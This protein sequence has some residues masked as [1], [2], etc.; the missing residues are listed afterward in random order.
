MG[1]SR[2]RP[3]VALN[4]SRCFSDKP[5]LSLSADR[6]TQSG[7]SAK[8]SLLKPSRAIQ[9]RAGK[10]FRAPIC[11]PDQHTA[12]VSFEVGGARNKRWVDW[13][14]RRTFVGARTCIEPGTGGKQMNKEQ[15]RAQLPS[16][17]S[18]ATFLC[19]GETTLS[20]LTTFIPDS[21]L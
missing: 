10:L 21:A 2:R 6:N 15:E 14:P 3:G 19:A 18:L 20:R 1:M 13:R 5:A 16:D 8:A 7:R 11:H 9:S 17:A 12:P 4:L